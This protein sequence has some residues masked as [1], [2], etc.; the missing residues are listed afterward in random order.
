MSKSEIIPN[1]TVC[2]DNVTDTQYKITAVLNVDVSFSFLMT[3][4][5]MP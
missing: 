5:R 2:F 3:G 4:L 1:Y